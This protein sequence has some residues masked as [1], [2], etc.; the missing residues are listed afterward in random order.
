MPG[1]AR[2]P[3][4][5]QLTLGQ[6]HQSA[7]DDDGDDYQLGRREEVLDVAPKPHAQRVHCS[8]EHWEG[9]SG[10]TFCS[11]GF[12]KVLEMSFLVLHPHPPHILHEGNRTEQACLSTF[13]GPAGL[14]LEILPSL[15]LMG[16]QPGPGQGKPLLT[17]A[18]RPGFAQHL[19]GKS[20]LAHFTRP[21]CASLWGRGSQG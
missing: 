21:Y 1:G 20:T 11:R 14:T 15:R 10:V 6:E 13:K 18:Y 5:L 9:P 3:S 12:P 19:P 8:D 4:L 7:D 17:A 2:H 16:K